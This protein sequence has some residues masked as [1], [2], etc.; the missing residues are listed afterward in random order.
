MWVCLCRK[1]SDSDIKEII[2]DHDT[3]VNKKCCI[4]ETAGKPQCGKCNETIK[5]IIDETTIDK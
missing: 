1:L 2:Q 5:G 4:N 3:C